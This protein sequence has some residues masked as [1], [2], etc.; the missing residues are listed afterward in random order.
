MARARR[1]RTPVTRA[2]TARVQPGAPPRQP[3]R[4]PPR[5]PPRDRTLAASALA[6]LILLAFFG[7]DRHVGLV[8]DGRQMIRTAVALAETGGIGQ[9]RGRDFTI[10]RAGGD[11]VSRFGMAMSVAQLPAALAAPAVETRLGPGSSQA[12]FLLAP[13]LAVGVAAAAAGALARRLGGGRPEVV[14][15]VLLASVASPLGSYASLEFSEPLQAATLAL[16]L[17]CALAAGQSSAVRPGFELAAGLAAGAAVLSKS[18]LILAAPAVLLP[19]VDPRA[20][21]RSAR[22]LT[23]AAAGAAMPLALWAYFELA[24]FGTF[25]GGYPDDRFTHPWLDGVWRLLVGPNRGLLLFWPALLLFA[26]AGARWKGAWLSTPASRAWLGAAVALAAQL[27]VAAGYWG[28]HGMEGWGPRLVVAAV[29]L[30]APFAAVAPGTGRRLLLAGVVAVSCAVNL[31][32]LLQHPTPVATY[33]MNLNWPAVPP[34]EAARYPFYATARS[35]DGQP[36]VVPFAPLELEPSANP[37]RLYWWFWRATHLAGE[38]LAERLQR[39]PWIAARPDLVPAAGW[40]QDVAREVA[41]PPR[42]GFLGRSLLGTGGPYATVY[43]D[44]LLDQV[45]RANQQGRIDR[46]LALSERRL[47]LRTDGEA[48]AWRLETLRRAGRAIDAERL[49]R[50]LPEDVRRDPHI[51]VVLALFDRDGG[52]E[53]R[54]RA[55][56][57]SVADSFPGTPVRQA[58][59]APLATW[60]ATL[61]AMTA[62]PRRDA[63]VA[64]PR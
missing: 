53:Q 57:G 7:D 29:P 34:D 2:G 13:W 55:L 8:A 25:F 16:A 60:P 20:P 22:A 14:A 26:W 35:A 3:P 44:A 17:V 64:A 52:E 48:A 9:A 45:V 18:S 40:P 24:R 15:A 49:L 54:A 12:L 61:D 30:L 47:R 50:S 4:Q 62:A 41:P 21:Q 38:S 28:W 32:P 5:R 63:M 23:R 36:T 1:R 51:N 6:V 19:L 10:D 43:L 59:T 39:P 46:A 27:G 42:T 31:P 58:L 33:V 11:A 37:W 56:L